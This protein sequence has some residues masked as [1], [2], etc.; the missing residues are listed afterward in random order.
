MRITEVAGMR[1]TVRWPARTA[2]ILAI[3]G[4]PL[5]ARAGLEV[6]STLPSYG[7]IAQFI[8]GDRVRV[9][10]ISRPDEDAH[11][12]KPK[13][14]L[15]LMLKRADLYVTTGLDLELWGPV[16]VDKSGNRTI[17]DGEPGFV[18]ASQ[19]VPLLGVPASTSRA[20]GDIHIYGNPH[21]HASPLNAKIIA[22]N[23]AAGLS[24]VDP[25]GAP[26]YEENLKAFRNR[27]D[28]S[29]YGKDLVELLGSELLDP[30]V[31]KGTLIPFLEGQIYQDHP[32]IEKLGGWLGVGRA[33]RGKKIIAYHKNW[34][35]LATLFGMEIV[36]YVEPKPGIPPSA[37]HVHDLI[38]LIQVEKIRVLLAA[39]YFEPTKPQAIADRTGCTVV[40]V[41]MQPGGEA[42]GDY[43]GLV[44]LWV[45]RLEEAFRTGG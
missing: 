5:P 2:L 29:L 25:A 41:P 37:R 3:L 39:T 6:V 40:R 9:S 27:I 13:P 19:G 15:A 30:L 28:V 10:S 12:V 42:A 34:I 16:L 43:F 14:S 44:D 23:I 8:G 18:A 11:F 38:H 20:G 45:R 35:Y 26:L 4:L 22:G 7:S 21:I 36:D 31:R 1:R 32:L 33:F 17:R 24:R